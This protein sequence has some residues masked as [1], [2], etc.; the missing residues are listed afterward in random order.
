LSRI[1]VRYTEANSRIKYWTIYLPALWYSLDPDERP[2]MISMRAPNGI[3]FDDPPSE[4]VLSTLDDLLANPHGDDRF[5]SIEL[6][7]SDSILT[8]YGV[9][10]VILEHRHDAQGLP[11]HLTNL[12][13][14]DL[15]N[16]C[17]R[18]LK[19]GDDLSDLN[20]KVGYGP[21]N[22][23]AFAPGF[24]LSVVDGFVLVGGVAGTIILSMIVWWW[25]FVLAFVLGHFFLFC[26]VVRMGRPLEFVW[27]G[28]FIALAAATIALATP[29]WL[30]T[31]LLSSVVTVI[32]VVVEMRKASYHG[33]GWKW[34]NPSLRDWWE[35]QMAKQT[36]G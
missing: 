17:L 24:R 36:G 21:M 7:D 18:F 3:T 30:M 13:L 20:W 31:T 33:V 4:L 27:G 22:L 10:L 11:C 1:G 29:G 25:G 5:N 8:T 23:P 9:S 35:G 28:V 19:A 6:V 14:A 34:I 12:T 2:K 26:N 32:L 16:V 15:R